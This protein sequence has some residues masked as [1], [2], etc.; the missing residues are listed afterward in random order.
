MVHYSCKQMVG[1]AEILSELVSLN[2]SA[3]LYVV[4]T[5]WTEDGTQDCSNIGGEVFLFSAEYSAKGAYQ[6]ILSN[7]QVDDFSIFDISVA[8]YKIDRDSIEMP[9]TSESLSEFY[10]MH[11]DSDNEIE[12]NRILGKCL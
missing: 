11:A 3:Y 1:V 9:I 8:R 4:E 12:S 6:E 7:V 2:G 10:A 5:S